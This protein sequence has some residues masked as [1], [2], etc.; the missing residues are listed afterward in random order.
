MKKLTFYILAA[1]TIVSAFI[2]THLNT[3]V[4]NLFSYL[5]MIMILPIILICV[6]ILVFFRYCQLK[7]PLIH[8]L[9]LCLLYIAALQGLWIF[10]DKTNGFTAICQNSINLFSEGFSIGND[11]GGMNIA[12]LLLPAGVSFLL[13]YISAYIASHRRGTN[14]EQG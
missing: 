9:I 10:M 12:D 5:A 6:I 2:V 1:I 7:N 8:S 4:L 13:F 3:Q 14:H 11:L